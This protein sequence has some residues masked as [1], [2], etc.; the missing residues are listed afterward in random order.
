LREI[1]SPPPGGL[2]I[3]G[4]VMTRENAS[5]LEGDD[6]CDV[7]EL[8]EEFRRAL[9]ETLTS[10]GGFL[11][12][13]GVWICRSWFFTEDSDSIKL[14]E[15]APDESFVIE[16]STRE[17]SDVLSLFDAQM[18]LK[19]I[20]VEAARRRWPGGNILVLGP[21][22]LPRFGRLGGWEGPVHVNVFPGRPSPFCQELRREVSSCLSALLP[23]I[24]AGGITKDG[25]GAAPAFPSIARTKKRLWDKDSI[26]SWEFGLRQ[27]PYNVVEEKELPYSLEPREIERL[28]VPVFACSE[29]QMAIAFTLMQVLVL[30]VANSF[31]PLTGR[32]LINHMSACERWA[33]NP[34]ARCKLQY[35][36]L[37][38]SREVLNTFRGNLY[39]FLERCKLPED[40]EAIV[41]IIQKGMEF[42][43]RGEEGDFLR[44]N[45]DF[46]GKKALYEEVLSRFFGMNLK[47]FNAS[48]RALYK[49]GVE[50]G[51]L[52][53]MSSRE[54][55]KVLESKSRK[56]HEEITE[57]L[58]RFDF[59]YEDLPYLAS[60]YKSMER[61]ELETSIIYPPSSISLDEASLLRKLL[62][63]HEFC[64]GLP[65]KTRA[66][67]R[68][69]AIACA[70]AAG[71][72]TRDY[73]GAKWSALVSKNKV[74]TDG[75]AEVLI[76]PF[77]D[78]SCTESEPILSLKLRGDEIDHVMSQI[79][80]A[81]RFENV[82]E[83]AI[84]EESPDYNIGEGRD[85]PGQLSLFPE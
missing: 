80:G 54:V 2:E 34:F 83:W 36:G 66:E 50:A 16:L 23:L 59:S 85:D 29:S 73:V 26:D 9:G 22:F 21:A 38:D 60:V 31:Y 44:E 70:I 65:R 15:R 45:F 28:H 56:R 10:N 69:R 4:A 18:K 35:G 76:L 43:I 46:F 12:G 63:N 49:L 64:S 48:V 77:G 8:E 47:E 6:W 19:G 81:E 57:N 53:E 51:E 71:R 30:M 82:L 1:V 3:H 25:F 39:A 13:H 72:W 27:I 20:I 79:P 78:P 33:E 32:F 61:L 5:A 75:L 40:M 58:S 17:C 41:E 68:K 24:S 67:A 74:Q 14:E 42:L 55:R 84:R 62:D 11:Y 7:H 37:V 52:K